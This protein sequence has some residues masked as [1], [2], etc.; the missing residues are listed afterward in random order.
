MLSDFGRKIFRLLP[1]FFQQGR[2][3][4]SLSVQ[5]NFVTRNKSFEEK[6]SFCY[7]VRTIQVPVVSPP[8]S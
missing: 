3:Y 6:S 1:N 7:C 2:K 4:Y 8:L 5:R